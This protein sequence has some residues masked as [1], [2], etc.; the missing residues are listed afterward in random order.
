[1]AVPTA[2]LSSSQPGPAPGPDG[3]LSE[4]WDI[5]GNTSAD[6]DSVAITSRFFARPVRVSGAVSW[7]ISGQTVTCTLMAALAASEVITIRIFGFP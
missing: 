5:T 3:L 2:A 1:M 7:A 4:D 6:G